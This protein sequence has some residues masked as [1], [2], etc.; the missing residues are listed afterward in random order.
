[1]KKFYL[2]FKNGKIAIVLAKYWALLIIS[3]M[4]G[5]PITARAV[6]TYT[7]YDEVAN[8]A[9]QFFYDDVLYITNEK[10]E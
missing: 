9:G 10:P 5:D 6:Q 1:M 8:V 3:P 2:V 7:F 4:T